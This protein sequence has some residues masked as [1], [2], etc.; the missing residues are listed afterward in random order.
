MHNYAEFWFWTGMRTSELIGLQWKNVDLE[1]NQ[2]LVSEAVVNGNR[3]GTKTNVSRTVL[4][5]SRAKAA[6]LRQYKLTKDGTV[7]LNHNT[8]KPWV[9]ESSFARHQWRPVLN[10]LGIRYRRPYNCRHTYATT[11]LMSGLYSAFCA[12]QLGHTV[13]IFLSTYARWIDG[14][15]NALEMGR[16]EAS[17]ASEPHRNIPASSPLRA[18]PSASD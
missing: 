4:L 6:L 13:D 16:L 15:R 9:D 2:V 11:M 12:G 1:R 5:N 7:F 17:I 3:K 18:D 10:K 14:D 8:L